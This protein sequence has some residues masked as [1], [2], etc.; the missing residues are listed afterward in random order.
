MAV[1]ATAIASVYQFR[2]D[3]MTHENAPDE[4]DWLVSCDFIYSPRLACRNGMDAS[5]T[6]GIFGVLDSKDIAAQL[7]HNNLWCDISFLFSL[8]VQSDLVWCAYERLLASTDARGTD[9]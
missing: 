8:S 5:Q 3:D 4:D 2:P 7:V 1:F 6:N 9:D